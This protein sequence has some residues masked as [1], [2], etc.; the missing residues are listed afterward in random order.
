ML[1]ILGP[2]VGPLLLVVLVTTFLN[3]HLV[4]LSILKEGA[5]KAEK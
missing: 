1:H 2:V 5:T 4:D 3:D